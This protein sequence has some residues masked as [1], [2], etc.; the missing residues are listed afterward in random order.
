MKDDDG[1]MMMT[2]TTTTTTTMWRGRKRDGELRN[3]EVFER[4]RISA[5]AAST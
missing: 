4:R 2:T 5:A 1:E 3:D